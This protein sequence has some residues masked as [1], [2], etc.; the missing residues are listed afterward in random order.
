M[1]TYAY[2]CIAWVLWIFQ[3]EGLRFARAP[4]WDAFGFESSFEFRD[5]GLAEVLAA[6]GSNKLE[7]GFRMN[8]AWNSRCPL[9]YQPHAIKPHLGLTVGWGWYRLG[10][11]EVYEL[12]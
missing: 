9:L 10:I 5:P 6:V 4:G 7:E 3:D 11:L 12:C 8:S 1:C 2:V